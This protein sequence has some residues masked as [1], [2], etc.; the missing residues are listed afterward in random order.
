MR[1]R[2]KNGPTCPRRLIVRCWVLEFQ[3]GARLRLGLQRVQQ[4]DEIRLRPLV[5]AFRDGGRYAVAR[6]MLV[7]EH[8]IWHEYG[9]VGLH[10]GYG[11][12]AA[13]IQGL[14][15]DELVSGHLPDHRKLRNVRRDPRVVISFESPA[16]AATSARSGPHCS[17]YSTGISTNPP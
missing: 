12:R 5:K 8:T 4:C 9:M 3:C 13:I 2:A 11:L 7:F 6:R 16:N 17:P 15:G 14:D 10:R 1:D